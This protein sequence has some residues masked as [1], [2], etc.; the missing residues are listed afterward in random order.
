[1][2]S[3]SRISTG[4]GP[5]EE[6]ASIPNDIL[7][8]LLARLAVERYIT[9]GMKI[10]APAAPSGVLAE[11]A[12][13]FVT[14]R[15][16]GGC[17]RGCIGTIQP[18]CE[19]LADEIILNAIN[20]ATKDPRFPG[21]VIHELGDLV[22]GVDVLS[23]PEPARGVEDLDPMRFG[24]I[25]E[26]PDGN[27]RALLLPGIEGIETSDEQWRAVHSKAGIKQGTLV[28][29]DRFTVRRYGKDT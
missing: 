14:I 19:N 15:G 5:Q 7:P 11:R 23:A 9:E 28:R 26:T 29:V 12:G 17:L 3:P 22:Y 20:A 24:V 16:P 18:L 6:G 2:N 27:H 10:A 4:S 1:M 25:I 21:I 8:Q 13:A